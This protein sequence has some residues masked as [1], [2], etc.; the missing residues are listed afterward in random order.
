MREYS[1]KAVSSPCPFRRWRL[2][3]FVTSLRN[4]LGA[5][6]DR[7]NMADFWIVLNAGNHVIADQGKTV[8][9]SK[10][11]DEDRLGGGASR[12]DAKL[13]RTARVPPLR[14]AGFA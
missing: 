8:S 7:G 14:L 11:T 13:V 12:K 2:A 1:S 3:P 10:S 5:S 4:K 9:G 6:L